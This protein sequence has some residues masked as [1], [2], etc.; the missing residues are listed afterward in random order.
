MNIVHPQMSNRRWIY[1]SKQTSEETMQGMKRRNRKNVCCRHGSSHSFLPRR[2]DNHS[3]LV[4][5]IGDL[6][7]YV[8]ASFPRGQEN[9][10]GSLFLVNRS[11][12]F[13]E[14]L[15]IGRRGFRSKGINRS[16]HLKSFLELTA[17]TSNECCTL[18]TNHIFAWFACLDFQFYQMNLHHT[19]PIDLPNLLQWI[20]W[21]HGMELYWGVNWMDCGTREFIGWTLVLESTLDAL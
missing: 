13:D 9:L 15:L 10:T 7:H 12:N 21:F 4:I 19:G 3:Q 18:L 1:T 5:G 6:T 8:P 16:D 20:P 2:S 11:G 14:E 17:G